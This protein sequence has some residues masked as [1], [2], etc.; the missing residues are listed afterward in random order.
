MRHKHCRTWN[1][2]RNTEK[3]GIGEIHTRGPGVW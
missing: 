2:A 1:K 3:R